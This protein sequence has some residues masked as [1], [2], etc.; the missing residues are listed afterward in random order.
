MRMALAGAGVGRGAPPRPPRSRSPSLSLSF[1]TRPGHLRGS[2]ARGAVSSSVVRPQI[3]YAGGDERIAGGWAPYG[4]A[5]AG[6]ARRR[7]LFHRVAGQLPLGVSAP[8]W[9]ALC[10]WQKAKGREKNPV[11]LRLWL[12]GDKTQ[13]RIQNRHSRT[14]PSSSSAREEPLAPLRL[15]DCWLTDSLGLGYIG[16]THSLPPL[17]PIAGTIVASN[18]STL[19][20]VCVLVELCPPA[21]CWKHHRTSPELMPSRRRVTIDL[22]RSSCSQA[23]ST[24]TAP[25]T[26]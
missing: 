12:V 1:P 15:L 2:H 13:I 14:V 25:S 17:C 4:V 26:F 23:F 5:S 18:N 8:G 20:R 3:A 22:C 24:P 7:E 6:G 10:Q 9:D 19:P 11:Q 21:H 16:G